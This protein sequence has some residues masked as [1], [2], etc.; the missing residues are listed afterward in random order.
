VAI[1]ESPV[2]VLLARIALG[3]DGAIIEVGGE[4]DRT[5]ASF[6]D[7]KFADVART[8]LIGPIR[9][10]LDLSR[11][12]HVDAAGIY[13]IL[14]GMEK[15]RGAGAE[16]VIHYPSP[17]ALQLS[18]MCS[19]LQI[20]DIQFGSNPAAPLIFEDMNGD[21]RPVAS[22]AWNGSGNP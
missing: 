14:Q 8:V 5:S 19:L 6:L 11:L 7:G 4:L 18:E 15:L 12:E 3:K 16:L 21:N 10:T 20:A 2:S 17:M 22:V 9:V 13:S 1:S